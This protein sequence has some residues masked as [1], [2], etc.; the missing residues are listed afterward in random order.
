MVD[1]WGSMR[2]G[3]P[4][5]NS[6]EKNQTEFAAVE[7]LLSTSGDPEPRYLRRL[8]HGVDLHLSEDGNTVSSVAGLPAGLKQGS[9]YIP[10][11][12]GP[13][14]SAADK[15]Q[16]AITVTSPFRL[17]VLWPALQEPPSWLCNEFELVTGAEVKVGLQYSNNHV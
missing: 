3:P 15:K 10:V 16:Y 6:L 9:Y 8:R 13:V 11:Q 14:S 2:L 5:R 1:L 4:E 7:C 17:Y 12:Q